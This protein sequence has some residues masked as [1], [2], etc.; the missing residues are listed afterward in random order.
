MSCR[1]CGKAFAEHRDRG[2]LG[3]PVPRMPCGLLKAFYYPKEDYGWLGYSPTLSKWISDARR[4]QVEA[5]P[6]IVLGE[7]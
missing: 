5:N 4:E 7:D 2:S 6:S 3:A 1:W